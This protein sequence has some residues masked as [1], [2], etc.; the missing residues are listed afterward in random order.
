MNRDQIIAAL[1]AH[2]G[3]LRR[4]GVEHAALFGSAARG[5]APAT[6]TIDI[7][8]ELASDASINRFGY[9]GR[10]KATPGAFY[11]P[12]RERRWKPARSTRL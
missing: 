8:I 9:A 5:D 12:A 1:R 7:L 6:S 11:Q 4:R 2:Q 3:E 10:V